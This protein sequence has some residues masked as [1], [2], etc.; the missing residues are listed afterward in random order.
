MDSERLLENM[1]RRTLGNF[2][3]YFEPNLLLFDERNDRITNFVLLPLI[4]KPFDVRSISVITLAL[5][6]PIA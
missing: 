4:L 5:F 3:K 1:G 6:L 2:W